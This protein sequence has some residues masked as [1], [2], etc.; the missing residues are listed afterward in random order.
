MIARTVLKTKNWPFAFKLMLGPIVALCSMI[1]VAYLGLGGLG[2]D[3]GTVNELQRTAQASRELAA[4]SGGV[5]E[6]NGALYRVLALQAARTGGLDA[7]AE[8]DKL[9]GR[10]DGLSTRLKDWQVTYAE[11]A[12]RADVDALITA[13]DNYK[14]AIDWVR[15]MLDVDFAAA[16][17][18]LRPFD[19]NYVKL[20]HELDVMVQA[21]TSLQETSAAKAR[22][23]TGTVRSAFI[24][25]TGGALF[26]VLATTLMLALTTVR[27]IREIAKATL[28]LADGHLDLD[29]SGLARRDELGAIVG[30]LGVFRASLERVADLQS[31]QDDHKRA[32]E[33]A[34]KTT[35]LLL[36]NGFEETIGDISG[37]VSMAANDL[38]TTARFMS[39][40]AELTNDRAACTA[41][42]AQD[43]ERGLNAVASSVGDLNLSVSQIGR[44]VSMSA[45]NAE[46]AATE[47]RRTDGIVGALIKNSKEIG[48][49]INLISKIAAQTKLLAL[50]ATIE[51]A[52]AGAAGNGFAVVAAEVKKLA[53]QT[54]R[55]TEQISTKIGHIQ[56]ATK[57]AANAIAGV[58]VTVEEVSAI[59]K[60]IASAVHEQG[61]VTDE[62]LRNV[63]RV[64]SGTEQVTSNISEVSRTASDTGSAATQ[65]LG[66][67]GQLAQQAHILDQKVVAFLSSVRDA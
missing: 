7:V 45:F 22:T 64:L 42:A 14:G 38:Q 51:A 30:S 16:V 20:N 55:A 26:I 12:Q 54:A 67:A 56:A 4:V 15:Q 52:R 53:L 10:V 48:E 35:L 41:G 5:Q 62:I 3:I 61:A 47:A 43:A 57:E 17:S 46:R 66:S 11:P 2:S 44:Q 65:V 23:D 19:E 39:G 33:L 21:F 63:R 24:I 49:V 59:A 40:A 27:S 25:V 8:L 9:R 29:L 36:A 37:I 50:N 60:L 31:E 58:T 34:R 13:I 28:A 1:V 18:F 6:I 32:L